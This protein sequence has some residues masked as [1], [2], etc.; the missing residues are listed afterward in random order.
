VG[1]LHLINVKRLAYVVRK[2]EEAFGDAMDINLARTA[3][4][5]GRTHP[6]IDRRAWWR[7]WNAI[8]RRAARRCGAG[9]GGPPVTR[10]ALRRRR[11]DFLVAPNVA[12]SV[13]SSWWTASWRAAAAIQ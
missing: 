7:R 8:W 12:S 4:G 5:R 3:I 11:G 1:P 9:R 13:A 6:G 10:R 2:P